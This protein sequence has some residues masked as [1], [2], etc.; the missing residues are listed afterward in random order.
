MTRF[1]IDDVPGSDEAASSSLRYTRTAILLH[2]LIAAL[3]IVTI[4]LGL[5]S[6][7]IRTTAE[8]PAMT[9]HK[10]IGI[11]ILLL[12]IVRLCWRL[13]H[14]VPDLPP[15][16]SWIRTVARGTH[17]LFYVLLFAMPLSGWWMSSAFHKHPITFGL[18]DVPYLPVA[19]GISSAIPAHQVHVTL[20][21]AM[22]ALLGL[23]V[24]AALKHHFV[25]HDQILSRMLGAQTKNRPL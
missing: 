18:F 1:A 10:A 22:I 21:W 9:A 7:S 19:Q 16:A 24:L 3:I 5:Y 23:H 14:R 4:P 11:T 25:D 20:G 12:T 6:A 15:M 8:L 17:F 13:G 2:W